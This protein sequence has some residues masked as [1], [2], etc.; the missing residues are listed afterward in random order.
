[1]GIFGKEMKLKTRDTRKPPVVTEIEIRVK[2]SSKDWPFIFR[3]GVKPEWTVSERWVA[4]IG[5]LVA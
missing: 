5:V 3:S 2:K 4:R 1:M